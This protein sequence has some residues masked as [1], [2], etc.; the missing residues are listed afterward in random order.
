MAE[1]PIRV[2]VVDDE[3]LVRKGLIALLQEVGRIDVV[4]EAADGGEAVAQAEALSP[5]VIL[6]DLMMPRMDGIEAIHRIAARQPNARILALTGVFVKD[7]VFPAI[8]AGAQGY[9]L[10]DAEPEDLVKAVRCLQGGES[11]LA[12]AIAHKILEEITHPAQT[13]TTPGKLQVEHLTE[14]ELEVLRMMAQ[15]QSNRAIASRLKVSEATVRTH[16]SNVLGKLHLANRV[17]A[18][19]YALRE[20]IASLENGLPG[21]PNPQDRR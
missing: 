19:L 17:Q 14:R 3:T 21:Q 18:T 8:K 4:G 15:G 7:Q 16:V 6:M 13:P 20:G 10:K 12:P 11:W 5:D 9:L 1:T 2:L